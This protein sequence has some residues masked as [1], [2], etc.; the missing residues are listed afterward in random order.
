MQYRWT[1]SNKMFYF[2]VSATRHGLTYVFSRWNDQREKLCRFASSNNENM[3][4]II[5][6]LRLTANTFLK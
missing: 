6:L 1:A 3:I 5:Y 2:I 4:D